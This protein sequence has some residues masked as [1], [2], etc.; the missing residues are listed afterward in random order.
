MRSQY[1][2]LTKAHQ[3][4]VNSLWGQHKIID[5]RTASGGHTAERPLLPALMDEMHEVHRGLVQPDFSG[6]D[7]VV[8]E[9]IVEDDEAQ[10]V[11]PSKLRR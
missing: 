6:K 2:R 4:T 9:E 1:I 11:E 3:T 7:F 8:W 5:Q 10:A